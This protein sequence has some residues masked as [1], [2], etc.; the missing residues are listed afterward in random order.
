MNKNFNFFLR[1]LSALLLSS[2][3]CIAT[4]QSHSPVSGAYDFLKNTL[5]K[6]GIYF[7]TMLNVSDIL[8]RPPRPQNYL[9]EMSKYFNYYTMNVSFAVVEK[10]RGVFDFSIADQV[11]DFAIAHHAKVRGHSLVYGG[12]IPSWVTNGNFSND[13]LRQI[14]KTHIQTIVKHFKDKYPGQV[15]A[16]QVSNEVVCNINQEDKEK[17]DQGIKQNIWTNIH[18]P[19]SN[20]SR[21]YLEMAFNWTH[22]IDPKAHLYLNE[23]NIE[24][25][26]NQVEKVN[27]VYDLVKYL[28]SQG[29]PI[30]GVGFQCH[31]RLYNKSKY[32]TA[33]LIANMNRFA[34]LG[35]ETQI[36]E[37]DVL[38]AHSSLPGEKQTVPQ[39]ITSPTE[40]DYVGQAQLYSMMF[41]ACLSSKNCTA[42][43]LGETADSGSWT[44]NH[45]K[46]SFRPHLFDENLKP[47]LAFIY[48]LRD[49]QK[50]R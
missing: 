13:T 11:V 8:L 42:F 17:C 31:L 36:T 5:M 18:K 22:E 26:K 41:N 37:A 33:G 47:K 49:A 19:N 46:Y 38:L 39:A 12:L 44:Y 4:A 2:T 30:N 16:W 40:D 9:S 24:M 14:L 28:K 27:R 10:K 48:L 15:V 34:D 50:I 25:A 35:L 45:W 20:D 6:K 43:I 21:D 23:N 3:L 1:S 7:G 32:N 29:T